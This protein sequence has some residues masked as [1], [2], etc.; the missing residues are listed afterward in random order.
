MRGE[1]DHAAGLG[2]LDDVPHVAARDGVHAR[3]RLVQEH[4]LRRVKGGE[5]KGAGGKKGSG[6]VAARDGPGVHARHRLFKEDAPRCREG[7]REKEG[8]GACNSDEG[9]LATQKK[10]GPPCPHLGVA[11]EGDGHREAALR[12]G[13]GKGEGESRGG[14]QG[15][16][17]SGNEAAGSPTQK[18]HTGGQSPPTTGV[19]ERAHVIG[20]L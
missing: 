13:G 15:G 7:G 11:N 16:H 19:S 10:E 12:G 8:G 4:D 20:P 1:H 2:S 5:E 6:C 9:P 18:A 14:P 3:R 17:V